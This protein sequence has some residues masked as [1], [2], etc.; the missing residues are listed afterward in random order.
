MALLAKGCALALVTLV[1]LALGAPPDKASRK[2]VLFIVVDDLRWVAQ[3][4]G[5]YGRLQTR[6]HQTEVVC[7]FCCR[8]HQLVLFALL[9]LNRPSIGVYGH[10][11]ARTPHLDKLASESL[12]FTNVGSFGGLSIE[13][14]AMGWSLS[15][16]QANLPF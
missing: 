14:D 4:Q 9:P 2:N 16:W 7:I 10:P 11:F 6:S 3:T 1:A 8:G 12:R 13:R 5:R 15:R